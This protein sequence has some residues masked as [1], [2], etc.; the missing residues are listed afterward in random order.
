MTST[1]EH[2]GMLNVCGVK[3]HR[4]I[5][6]F[7]EI[8]LVLFCTAKREHVIFL[9]LYRSMHDIIISF[10]DLLVFGEEGIV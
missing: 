2:G 5:V 1:D 10:V 3:H 9:I 8:N 4:L 6:R 7:F